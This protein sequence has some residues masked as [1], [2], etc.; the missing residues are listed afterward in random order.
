MRSPYGMAMIDSKLF[1]GEGEN[2]LTIFD[3]TN[4]LELVEVLHDG[5]IQ[6]FDVME[7]PTRNDLILIAGPNGL[8]Q[9]IINENLGFQLES[10]ISY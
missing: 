6:A 10:R 8:E 5:S 7:H 2:G 1:V 4:K 3:A 9:Y